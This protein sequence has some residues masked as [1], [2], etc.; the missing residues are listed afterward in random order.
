MG[1]P[2]WAVSEIELPF[3]VAS[4]DPKPG[5]SDPL[6]DDAGIL[7]YPQAG[8]GEQPLFVSSAEIRF[9]ALDL[10]STLVNL[11]PM[12]GWVKGLAEGLVGQDFI[13]GRKLAGWER[14]LNVASGLPNPHALA[15]FTHAVGEIEHAAHEAKGL[16]GAVAEIQHAAHTVNAPVHEVHAGKIA[17]GNAGP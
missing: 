15:K 5:G 14:V 12:L 10:A 7:V 6:A 3:D 17:T 13:S 8:A 9:Q 11:V 16:M 4:I 2:A 1:S